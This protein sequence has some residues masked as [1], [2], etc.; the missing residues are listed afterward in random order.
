MEKYYIEYDN[1]K[2]ENKGNVMKLI[3][4]DEY[5]RFKNR[6]KNKARNLLLTKNS[7]S[8]FDYTKFIIP[9]ATTN[10]TE[11]VYKNLNKLCEKIIKNP[12]NTSLNDKEIVLL[13]FIINKKI[14]IT[15]KNTN[16]LVG[17][18]SVTKNNIRNV[19]KTNPITIN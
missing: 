4:L 7:N 15:F 8:P 13:R 3:K 12:E 10:D 1:F 16:E 18:F 14:P 17:L 9:D 5:K 11:L 19:V 2:K 6:T